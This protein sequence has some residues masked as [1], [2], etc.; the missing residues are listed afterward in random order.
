[1]HIQY[2]CGFTA[3]SEWVNFDASPTLRWERTP[4]LGRLYTKNSQRFPANVKFGD[5]VA[6]LPVT[7]KSCEGVYASHVLEH[8]AL[9]DFDRAVGNTR[10]ILREGGIFRLVVP[11]LEWA[12]REYLKR[13]EV[14]DPEANCFFL[15]ETNLGEETR[16]QTPMGF[17]REWL[18]TSRHRWMW[19][20][21]S[22]A[23][24]LESHGFTKVRRCSFGDCEDR[25]FALVEE[26]SRFENA[27]A[28]EARG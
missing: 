23:H 21:G 15:G 8:L 17:L 6:G 9:K 2:G 1:M 26:K 4:I 7:A 13:V 3:P 10:K 16:H 11:D 25:M 14:E 27:V 5:I 28:M 22:L 24:A 12:A 18:R 20:A 19:D